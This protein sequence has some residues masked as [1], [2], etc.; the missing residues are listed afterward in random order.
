M[1]GQ[2]F[3]Q[4]RESNSFRSIPE[5]E[6]KE[7]QI[8]LLTQK[9]YKPQ[10]IRSVNGLYADCRAVCH[11][12]IIFGISPCHFELFTCV[13]MLQAQAFPKLLR[14]LHIVLN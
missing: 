2:C 9:G 4:I 11:M 10:K 5:M 14:S 13:G 3:P 1:P 7:G 8:E 6:S 12:N